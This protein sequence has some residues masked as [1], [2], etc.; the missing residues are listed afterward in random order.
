MALVVRLITPPPNSPGK[1][2]EKLFC[3][4]VEA[5]TLV[6]KMSRGTTRLSGSGLGSGEPLSSAS[7]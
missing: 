1:L 3:T 7:E 5:M 2:A 6:G 4:S